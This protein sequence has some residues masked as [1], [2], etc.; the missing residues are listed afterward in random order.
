[1]IRRLLAARRG[2]ALV[3]CAITLNVLLLL[4]LGVLDAGRAIWQYN[5]VAFLARDGARYGTIPSRSTTDIQTYVRTR[6]ASMLSNPC[7]SA[8]DFTVSVTRGTCGS[9]TA[10]V[11]VTVTDRFHA[12]TPIIANLW[13]S[14]PLSLTATSQMY[15]EPGPPGGCAA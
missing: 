5:T 13:G 11:I 9:T 12:V 15:V 8:P 4:T 2:Q 14:G 7:P 1:V 6:C 3:E 10:P